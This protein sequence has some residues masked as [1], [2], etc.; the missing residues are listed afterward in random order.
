MILNSEQRRVLEWMRDH[1]FH[2]TGWVEGD[3]G[4]DV[5]ELSGESSIRFSQET[6]FSLTN[7]VQF[8]P[9]ERMQRV[10]EPTDKA[11]ALL[12]LPDLSYISI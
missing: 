5:M 8:T 7:L 4:N 10:F 12:D 1:E 3:N 6:A 2:S 9:A 11:L